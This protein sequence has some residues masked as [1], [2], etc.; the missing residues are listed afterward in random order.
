MEAETGVTAM[1]LVAPTVGWVRTGQ[2]LAL[3]TDGG[4]NWTDITPPATTS[5]ELISA[6]FLDAQH[7]WA[8]TAQAGANPYV[9]P[10]TAIVYHTSDGGSSWDQSSFEGP[11]IAEPGAPALRGIF[12]F[13]DEMHGWFFGIDGTG[14]SSWPTI[15]LTVDG[16]K[17]W[18]AHRG[19][20][21]CY[22]YTARFVDGQNGWL[23]E[24]CEGAMPLYV[25]HDGG[26]TWQAR[27]L[28][29]PKLDGC[30]TTPEASYSIPGI[31]SHK[32]AVIVTWRCDILVRGTIG[33]TQTASLYVSEDGGDRWDLVAPVDLG[34]ISIG[35]AIFM[36]DVSGQHWTQVAPS[37]PPSIEP[38][39]PSIEPL[40]VSFPTAE[41]GWLRA[42]R[43][44]SYAGGSLRTDYPLFATSDGGH[45]WKLLQP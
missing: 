40:E 34:I 21:A 14:G 41:D 6:F 16:G 10:A 13:V 36:T 4:Q 19:P 28:P 23:V 37:W 8:A 12:Q 11:P 33:K 7:G 42:Q 2:R 17:T 24:F 38:A 1:Q 39:G 43:L 31:P 45:S 30:I 9:D 15:F 29:T 26:E 27:D 5:S 35:A 22:S 25:T 3:T 32:E 44:T 20:R 18:S